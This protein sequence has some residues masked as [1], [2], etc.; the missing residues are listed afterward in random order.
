M[1]NRFSEATDYRIADDELAGMVSFA[2]REKIVL[3]NGDDEYVGGNR[4]EVILALRGDDLVEG[5]RGRDV[6]RGGRGN[7]NLAGGRGAD[8][9]QGGAGNDD[10]NG[11]H[12][13]D[14]LIGGD[15]NDSLEGRGG[16][17]H[18]LGGLGAD[19][20]R[21]NADGADGRR[22]TVVYTSVSES[23]G[24]EIDRLS[25]IQP[26]EDKI[27]LSAIDADVTTPED[28]AFHFIGTAAFSGTAGELQ[29]FFNAI[30]A[31]I[32]GDGNA[33]FEVDITSYA[34]G[35]TDILHAHDFVL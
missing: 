16:A 33:D 10:L 6:I 22:D 4:D 26:G 15:G 3:T 9:I 28:D 21:V 11:E 34:S 12:G 23:S 32:D 14:R 2:R 35:G 27:D 31:D 5:A 17:D 7:D 30:Y 29:C 20:V 1:R 18:F 24:G 13:R 25:A 19:Q 8:F